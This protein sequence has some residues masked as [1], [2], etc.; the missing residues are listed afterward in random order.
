M[1]CLVDGGCP[2][3]SEQRARLFWVE[4]VAAIAEFAIHTYRALLGEDALHL[5]TAEHLQRAGY[6]L[7]GA[8]TA[9]TRRTRP[10]C[11]HVVIAKQRCEQCMRVGEPERL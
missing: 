9:E 2:R 10:E 1:A 11:A 8:G 5:G 4:V 3:H 6:S 7:P